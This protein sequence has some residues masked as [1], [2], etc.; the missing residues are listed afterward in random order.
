MIKYEIDFKFHQGGAVLLVKIIDSNKFTNEIY[1]IDGNK[2]ALREIF[3]GLTDNSIKETEEI[4][5]YLQ[6]LIQIDDS[7]YKRGEN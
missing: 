2:K 4:Q 1:E 6:D 7:P 5:D 3:I